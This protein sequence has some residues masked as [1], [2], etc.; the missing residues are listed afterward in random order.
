MSWG[1]SWAECLGRCDFSMTKRHNGRLGF[2]HKAIGI[3]HWFNNKLAEHPRCDGLEGDRIRGVERNRIK[4]GRKEMMLLLFPK[5]VECYI[6]IRRTL[7][8]IWSLNT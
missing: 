4:K 3:I 7:S 6:T 5:Q 1:V 8:M 2:S